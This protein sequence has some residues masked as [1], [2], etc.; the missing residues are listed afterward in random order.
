D[1]RRRA[2]EVQGERQHLL[3]DLQPARGRAARA[4]RRR[5]R[6]GG[7]ILEDTDGRAL[8]RRHGERRDGRRIACAVTMTVSL[9]AAAVALALGLALLAPE[10]VARAHTVGV[11][12]GEYRLDGRVLYG[13]IGMAGRELARA[14]P[15]VDAD[16]DGDIDGAELAAARDAVTKL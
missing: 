11:S 14:L 9:R 3:A 4:Q 15:A 16:H 2:A 8:S 13:E 7:R 1:V 5:D 10:G 12:S 6:R